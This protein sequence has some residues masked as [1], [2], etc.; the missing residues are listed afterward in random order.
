[1]LSRVESMIASSRAHTQAQQ[2]QQA[3]QSQQAQGQTHSDNGGATPDA[4]AGIR[5]SISG[6]KYFVT[7]ERLQTIDLLLASFE[8]AT[9]KNQELLQVREQLA[10]SEAELKAAKETIQRLNEELSS[11][12]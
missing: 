10:E 6:K 2:A 7:R 9:Q 8:T 5:V 4:E 11:A 12:A 3:Q 1:L